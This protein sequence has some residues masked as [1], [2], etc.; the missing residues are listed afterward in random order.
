MVA[1]T[2]T[3]VAKTRTLVATA[4]TALLTIRTNLV[5]D[6]FELMRRSLNSRKD[7]KETGRLPGSLG[8]RPVTARGMDSASASPRW[9]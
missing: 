7:R 1:M 6:H 4:P 9:H 2:A 8:S 5:Q 3:A